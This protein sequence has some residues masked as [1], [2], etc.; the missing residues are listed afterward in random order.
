MR[1]EVGLLQLVLEVGH[2]TQALDHAT[3]TLLAA[4]VH[5]KAR[6]G[7][8]LDPAELDDTLLL[9][10][11]A[12]HVHALVEGE[13]RANATLGPRLGNRDRHLREEMPRAADHIDV[14]ERHRVEGTRD[15]HVLDMVHDSL[16]SWDARRSSVTAVVPFAFD[17]STSQPA[18]A[19]SGASVACS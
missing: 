12:E 4:E 8:D 9:E 6:E 10:R 11:F 3:G 5:E 15:D 16:P 17:L 19:R 13:G 14:S 7:Q 1:V 18:R 2:G